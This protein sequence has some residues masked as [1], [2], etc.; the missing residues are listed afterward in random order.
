MGFQVSALE[1]VIILFEGMSMRDILRL[2]RMWG[3]SLKEYQG[4]GDSLKD[5]RDA[6]YSFFFEGLS[7]CRF[8]FGGIS[9]RG[10]SEKKCRELG[11]TNHD[12]LVRSF[13]SNRMSDIR[14][15]LICDYTTPS[16]FSHDFAI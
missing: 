10:C 2:P 6:G 3:H 14:L 4:V 15:D 1:N 13:W 12:F 5:C 16:S 8:F 9:K 11:F 7:R